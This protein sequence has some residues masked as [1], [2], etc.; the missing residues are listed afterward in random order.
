MTLKELM[1]AANAGFPNGYL[2]EYYDKETGQAKDGEGDT[3][4]RFIVGELAQSFDPSAGPWEQLSTAI[5]I[6]E[7]AQD[8]M[9]GVIQALYKNLE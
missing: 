8:D 7:R 1:Q 6:L 5:G 3:L 2:A 4:A 9:A